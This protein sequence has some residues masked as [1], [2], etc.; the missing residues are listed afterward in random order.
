MGASLGT[1]T[2]VSSSSVTINKM[3][4]GSQGTTTSVTYAINSDTKITT[5]SADKAV[6]VG[7]KVVVMP[8]DPNAASLVAK[9][10]MVLPARPAKPAS[11]QNH[12]GSGQSS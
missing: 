9:S 1:V 8:I 4:R 10:I 3:T 11:T 2:T 7:D 6:H 5:S 12:S